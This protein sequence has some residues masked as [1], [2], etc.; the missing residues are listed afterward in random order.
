MKKPIHGQV[1]IFILII[2]MTG[3]Q[4][5]DADPVRKSLLDRTFGRR[6][7]VRFPS[8]EGNSKGNPDSNYKAKT[9]S[10]Q[11]FQYIHLLWPNCVLSPSP[12]PPTFP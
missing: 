7:P 1:V 3:L 6:S 5:P 9:K 11:S 4:K 12:P 8:A 10:L 2:K